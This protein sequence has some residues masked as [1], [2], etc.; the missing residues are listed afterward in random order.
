MTG[1]VLDAG[2][3]AERTRLAWTRTALSILANAALLT[4][5]GLVSESW[6]DFLPAVLVALCAT[7]FGA[8]GVVRYRHVHRAVAEGTAVT[9]RRVTRVTGI[10]AVLPGLITLVTALVRI[11]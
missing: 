6:W 1:A 7:A 8:C 9:G 4:H 3:Q 10:I 2:L 5:L 11:G